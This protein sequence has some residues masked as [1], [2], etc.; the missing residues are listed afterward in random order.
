MKILS[1]I[2]ASHYFCHDVHIIQ[3]CFFMLYFN[4]IFWVPTKVNYK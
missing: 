3:L 4:S 2:D 1:N